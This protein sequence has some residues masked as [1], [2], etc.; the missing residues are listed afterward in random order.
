MS[1]GYANYGDY[2]PQEPQRFQERAKFLPVAFLV[3]TIILLYTIYMTFHIVPML[4]L[5]VPT[6]RQ[7][8]DLRSRAIT[9]CI[10][11][12]IA[13]TFLVICYVRAI[14]TF[15]GTVPDNDPR[16]VYSDQPMAK[17]VQSLET[18]KTGD[19]R[20][21]KWCGKYKPDRCHHCRV[22][23]TCILKMDHHCPWIYNCVGFANY[24]YFFLVLFYTVI[25]L[26]LIAFTMSDSVLKSWDVNT[27]FHVMFFVLFGETLAI[28]LGCLITA[29]YSFHVWLMFKARTTIEFCEKAMPKKPN[30]DETC[31]GMSCAELPQSAYDMG[32]IG[33][34]MAVLGPN[35]LTWFLP[36]Q[37]PDGDGLEYPTES[38]PFGRDMEANRGIRRISHQKTQRTSYPGGEYKAAGS[39]GSC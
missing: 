18:K 12:H 34:V 35:P 22:C 2:K 29:F 23:R 14:L 20:H 24:K 27:P 25:D 30:G 6:N 19:R 38:I 26:W 33:N 16:W 28:F 1:G 10:W 31:C 39:G 11:F 21:C 36:L 4:Q 3:T 5:E 15:P 9:H 17:Q 8:D 32:P 37:P 7:D 13:T